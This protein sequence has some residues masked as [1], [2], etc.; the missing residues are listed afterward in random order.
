[1]ITQQQNTNQQNR[2]DEN[3]FDI[4]VFMFPLFGLLLGCVW[5]LRFTY[6]QFFNVTS[7][8][9]LGGIS[10]LYLAAYIS[11]FRRPVNLEHV[12]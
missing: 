10:F 12:D 7:T 5:Y 8:L 4:G 2:E 11:S 6:R 3:G 9:T 1:L